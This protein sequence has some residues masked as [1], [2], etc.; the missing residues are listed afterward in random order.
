MERTMASVFPICNRMKAQ[1]DL[2][3][4]NVLHGGVFMALQLLVLSFAVVQVIA[5]FEEVIG[6][7]KRA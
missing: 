5:H 4:N 1:F 3:V 7:E 6:A 2:G